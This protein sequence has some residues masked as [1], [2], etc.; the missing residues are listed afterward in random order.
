[1]FNKLRD[2]INAKISRGVTDEYLKSETFDKETWKLIHIVEDD[3]RYAS[4]RGFSCVN[5]NMYETKLE[6]DSNKF[7]E[8]FKNN[9][10][11]FSDVLIYTSSFGYKVINFVISW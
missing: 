2:I 11:K 5:K 3:I 4:A 10:Y 8:Y 1:M 6:V 7:L 9:G